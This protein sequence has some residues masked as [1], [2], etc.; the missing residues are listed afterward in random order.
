MAFDQEA[1]IRSIDVSPKGCMLLLGAGASATSGVLTAGQCIWD[2]K[3]QIFLTA[4]PKTSL[5]LFLDV[6]LPNVQN[7]IQSWLDKQS[8]FPP[9][10]H[11]DE[12]SFYLQ[13]AYP[14]AEDRKYY[15]QSI[16]KNAVPHVG[17]RALA[18]LL[19]KPKIKY[20]WTTNFD[21]LIVKSINLGQ[22]RIIKEIGLDSLKRL[23]DINEI[24]DSGYVISLHGDFRYD[25]LKNT[26]D[27]T[28][29][30]DDE[31]RKLMRKTIECSPL[32]VIGYSGRDESVMSVL[33]EA[34]N[35]GKLQGLYWC[36]RTG[37]PR[38]ER[39]SALINTLK[40][41]G[42]EAEIVE[43]ND[44]DDFMLRLSKYLLRVDPKISEIEELLKAAE[45]QK[46]PF[47]LSGYYPD[48]NWIFS[49]G[50]ELEIPK[51]IFQ[52]EAREITSWADL[53][54]SIK[55]TRILAGLSRNKILA[56]GDLDEIKTVFES[57]L[58]SVINNIPIVEDGHSIPT[59][60]HHILQD[61]LVRAIS[62][63]SG[64]AHRYDLIWD[65]STKGNLLIEGKQFFYYPAMRV[66]ISNEGKRFYLNLEPDIEVVDATGNKPER[67]I[68]KEAKRKV[69]T[70][71]Y[72]K[73]YH[74]ALD[75]WE[76]ILFND[77]KQVVLSYPDK[78]S[79][80]VHFILSAPR[81]CAKVLSLQKS[82]QEIQQRDKE[83][84][85]SIVLEEPKLVFGSTN[86]AYKPK[87]IHPLRGLVV[88]GPYDLN[89][90]GSGYVREARIGVICPEGFE[91][92]CCEFLARLNNKHTNIES[93]PEYLIPYP[94]FLDVYKISLR[95]PVKGDVNWVTIPNI[96][97]SGNEIQKQREIINSICS[98]IDKLS[99]LNSSDVVGI[100]IPSTWKSIETVED[101]NHRS[102]LH[103]LVK[104]YCAEKGISTQFLRERTT[105]K[106][107]MCEV[108]WWISM[109]IYAKALKTPF[110]L[111]NLDS[112]TVFVGIGYGIDKFRA[113]KGVVLGCS[114]IFDGAGRG[115]RYQLSKIENP[116]MYQ[117]NPHLTEEDALRIATQI[118][119][120]FYE[121]YHKLP[122]R[123]VIHKRTIFKKAE[124]EGLL[125]GLNGVE[126]VEMITIQHEDSWRYTAYS[127]YKQQV[128]GFPVQRGTILK[129]SSN[130]FL[131]WVHGNIRGLSTSGYSYFQGKSRIPTPLRII[132]FSGNSS[133]QQIANEILGLSKMNWNTLDMYGQFPVTLETSAEI[134]RIGQ[135]MPR[136][137]NKIYDY[138][139]FM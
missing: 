123:V 86:S 118:R 94:S 4:N 113:G 61:A 89:L 75:K 100:F 73:F 40:Q 46:A 137:S 77:K 55:N 115:L 84:F 92:Q 57:R 129:L 74:E 63:N 103:D 36:V 68:I 13:Y 107:H 30:L 41:K 139:L 111:D 79:T 64:L 44:F 130:Q 14:K 72:N 120:V 99:I 7:T 42:H 8:K 102:D 25:S 23:T 78:S 19:S 122:R 125:R 109:A 20:I 16:I 97:V 87:D 5:E 12:Y 124:K 134:S 15:F 33:D 54:D 47:S 52:F 43:I 110:L 56:V 67:S 116:I 132:R 60:V 6:S 105:L 35:N 106:Q 51:Q 128:D 66:H 90:N 3:K 131:L 2:L 37:E 17:Y 133:M 114:H 127:R 136:H 135:L 119:Q 71:Q 83:L 88:N 138:R 50:L 1:L 93:K 76:K 81:V 48:S 69:L 59:V 91:K 82:F 121:T 80:A 49:N 32:I 62:E 104:A 112:D 70:G 11:S 18:I 58:S 38:S 98:S 45:P 95:L 39:V 31:L 34:A 65:C 126:D 53:R 101:E 24:D 10:G 27:E 29:R 108:L 96:S 28:Q 9:L 22:T 21:S 117:E 26:E 85:D